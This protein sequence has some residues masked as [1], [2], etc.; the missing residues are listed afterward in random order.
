M[1]VVQL[2]YGTP[3]ISLKR[4]I[5]FGHFNEG[6]RLPFEFGKDL[7][8]KISNTFGDQL[9]LKSTFTYL[10]NAAVEGLKQNLLGPNINMEFFMLTARVY[11]IASIR[12][13]MGGT[14]IILQKFIL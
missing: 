3:Y 4:A 8:Q 14:S 6:F 2:G 1:K 9:T 12:L 7:R 13:A 10:F 5:N 11:F